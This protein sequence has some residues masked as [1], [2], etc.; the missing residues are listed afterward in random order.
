MAA[1]QAEDECASFLLVG[2]LN[3]YHREWL[4]STITIVMV[5]QPLT[6][7]LCRVVI[8]WWSAQPMYV[9]VLLTS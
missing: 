8:S 9:V 2:D 3:G 7:R 6:S 4:G 5:L 1:V